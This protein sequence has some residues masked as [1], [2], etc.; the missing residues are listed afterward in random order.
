MRLSKANG[1]V[2]E[3]HRRQPEGA[4][5]G[6]MRHGEIRRTNDSNVLKH[7]AIYQKS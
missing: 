3:G 5:N 2:S 4:P 6:Q 1:V 7:T